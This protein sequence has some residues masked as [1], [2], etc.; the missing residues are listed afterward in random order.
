MSDTKE[1]CKYFASGKCKFGDSCMNLHTKDVKQE[2]CSFH[3]R[4]FCKYGKDCFFAHPKEQQSW[5]RKDDRDDIS[6]R[7]VHDYNGRFEP[8]RFKDDPYR[9]ND[10]RDYR[11]QKYTY[12]DDRDLSKYNR[13]GPERTERKDTPERKDAPEQKEVPEGK[14]IPVPG[15]KG[16]NQPVESRDPD[17]RRHRY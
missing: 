4:G 1:P 15:R 9:T 2:T 6:G 8:K 12:S 13:W 11:T 10:R 3:M 17:T 16:M 14:D 5:R 7:N